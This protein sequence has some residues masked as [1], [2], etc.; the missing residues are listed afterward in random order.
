MSENKF[1]KMKEVLSCWDLKNKG[2]RKEAEAE[3]ISQGPDC[4]W[5]QNMWTSS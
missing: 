5:D 4:E 1:K 2:S 3:P